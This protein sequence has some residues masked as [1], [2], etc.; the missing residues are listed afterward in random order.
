MYVHSTSAILKTQL[1]GDAGA[2][3]A[4][5]ASWPELCLCVDPLS[6]AFII[7]NANKVK[8]RNAV[9]LIHQLLMGQLQLQKNHGRCEKSTKEEYM[10][11]KIAKNKILKL[12]NKK[13]GIWNLAR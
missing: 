5:Q 6:N 3:G 13:S 9:T 7:I 10:L 12:A 8:E 2:G 4:K 1:K 11:K